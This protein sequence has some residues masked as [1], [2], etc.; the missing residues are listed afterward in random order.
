[1]RFAPGSVPW[2]IRH[3]LRLLSRASGRLSWWMLLIVVLALIIAVAVVGAPIAALL[4][5]PHLGT[6]PLA[7]FGADIAIVLLFGFMF[8]QALLLS[9][10]AFYIRGDLDLLLS[11][12]LPPRRLVLVRSGAIACSVA[13]L[14]WLLAA[15]VVAATVVRGHLAIIGVLPLIAAVALAATSAGL[16]VA[17]VL[18]ATLGPRRARTVSQLLGPAVVGGIIL[19]AQIPQF[20]PH[21]GAWVARWV[22]T[23]VRLGWFGPHSVLAWPVR[24]ACWV[25]VP[26]LGIT[27]A[28]SVLFLATAYAAAPLFPNYAARATVAVGGRARHRP[29]R[30]FRGGVRS[31]LIRKELR[32]IARDPL[33]LSQILLQ[34]VYLIP[35][36]VALATQDRTDR[37]MVIMVCVGLLIVM[38]GGVASSLTWVT[39]SAEDAPDLLRCAPLAH[40]AAERAKLTAALIPLT[41]FLV[42]VAVL[43]VFSSWAAMIA[44]LGA[45]ASALSNALIQLWYAKPMARGAFRRRVQRALLPSLGGMLVTFGWVGV[46]A[47]ACSA[48][49][50]TE[51]AAVLLAVVPLGALGLLWLGRHRSE[52]P[53]Y[54]S[55]WS[56][57]PSRH[58]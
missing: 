25:P 9:V 57:E 53:L 39:L 42:P 6:H 30:P 16:V 24:A 49:A 43:G 17:M 48:T 12:P 19:L 1:M 52:R 23:A 55:R 41:G 50:A 32:L 27:A 18:F 8:A 3:E 28:C 7:V 40:G 14:F 10:Q 44:A 37:H 21:H 11:S 46:A 22:E 13:A 33:L 5:H 51:L 56:H 4:A 54:I 35:L 20:L 15:P 34:L 45:A 38:A 31:V 58:A 26:M 47:A 29:W 2:L 36:A